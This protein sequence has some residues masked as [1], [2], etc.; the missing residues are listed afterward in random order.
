MSKYSEKSFMKSF[1]YAVHG[2]KLAVKSQKNFLRQI[3]M[4][5]MAIF[6]GLF[7][8]FGVLEFCILFVLIAIVLISEMFNSVIEFTIDAVFKNKF[9]KLAG[10]AKD[11]SAGAVCIASFTALFIGFLLFINK[12]LPLIRVS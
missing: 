12:I 11:M 1:G 6:T 5:T 2:L 8:H 10:M 3:I 7:L 4:A 9:S